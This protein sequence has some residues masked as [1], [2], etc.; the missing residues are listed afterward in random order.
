[1]LAQAGRGDLIGKAQ[2]SGAEDMEFASHQSQTNDIHLISIIILPGRSELIGK[3][4][5]LFAPH[6]DNVTV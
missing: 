1:M 2:A 6:Q 5:D 4:N 3:D